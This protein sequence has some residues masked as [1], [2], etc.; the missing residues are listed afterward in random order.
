MLATLRVIDEPSSLERL[1]GVS[2][3]RGPD[4][5][6]GSIPQEQHPKELHLPPLASRSD[7]IWAT[8]LTFRR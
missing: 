6:A 5:P 8:V 7:E 2:L 1:F 3:R 4:L